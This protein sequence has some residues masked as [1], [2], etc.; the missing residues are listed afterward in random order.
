MRVFFPK[1]NE[2]GFSIEHPHIFLQNKYS[3]FLI[4]NLYLQKRKSIVH[5]LEDPL[6]ENRLL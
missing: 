5:T 2:Q 6:I 1:K 4:P 3:Y